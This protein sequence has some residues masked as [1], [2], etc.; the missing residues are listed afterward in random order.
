MTPE[1]LEN[2]IRVSTTQSDMYYHIPKLQEYAN[3]T[4]HGSIIEFGVRAMNS[5]WGLLSGLPRWMMS[6]DFQP[7]TSTN[8]MDDFYKIAKDNNVS[9]EFKL[10]STLEIEIPAVGFLFIDSLHTYSQLKTELELHADKVLEYI[11]FHD[12]H[13]FAHKG[14]QN[15]DCP[16]KNEKGLLDAV[17]E[18]MKTHREWQPEYSTTNCNGL[19]IIKRN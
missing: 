16:Y 10:E 19:T 15:S 5:S 18:F 7:P 13:L 4:E 3:K 9:Y 2:I 17:H 12:T 14:Q 6:Y 8:M 11:G 1:L